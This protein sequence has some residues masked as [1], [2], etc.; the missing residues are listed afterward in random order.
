MRVGKKC[1]SSENFGIRKIKLC[2][3]LLAFLI[4]AHG[5][6]SMTDASAAYRI[7][8]GIPDPS[9]FF[10]VMDPIN[11]PAPVV[12][13]DGTSAYCPSWPSSAS[14]NPKC[15]YVDKTVSGCNN[16]NASGYGTPNAPRCTPPEGTL[17]AGAFVYIN[18]GTYV[19]GDSG[20]QNLNWDGV[21]TAS[22]PIWIVGNPTTKPIIRDQV[23]IGWGRTVSYMVVENLEWSGYTGTTDFVSIRPLTDAVSIDHVV[24]RN[25]TMIG[26]GANIEK[27]AISVGMSSS[28]DEAPNSTI[29]YVV[30]YNNTISNIAR[31]APDEY[32][33][34]C[35]IYHSYHVDSVW[36]LHNTIHT[37]QEDGIAGSHYSNASRTTTNLYIG[38]NTLYNFGANAIDLKSVQGFV[39]S[40]NDFSMPNIKAASG[41]SGGIV[42][43][44]SAQ[45]SS[46][47]S[48]PCTDGWILFNK[49][50]KVCGGL[51]FVSGNAVE[52]M[53]VV[54]N[55]F[56]DID[57]N[58]CGN[59]S[60][61]YPG[62]AILIAS[63]IGN[64]WIVDN[65]FYDNQA[66]IYMEGLLSSANIKIHG[67]IFSNINEDGYDV[68]TG[69]AY[70]STD[71]NYNQFYHPV[72]AG[73]AKI[74]WNG[75]SRNLTYMKG[76]S[77]C[78]NCKEGNPLL[79]N[80]PMDMSLQA[81]SPAKD[82]SVQGPVG[83]TVY[84]LFYATYGIDIKADRVGGARP[85]NTL[86]DIG[87]F[88]FGSL[89]TRDLEIVT[90]AAF[91]RL[92]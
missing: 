36:T 44:H 29:Q 50:N 37:I 66:P 78:T 10:G 6:V 67:N 64:G 52:D 25:C 42:V 51:G 63:M 3:F 8:K 57:S 72:G 28:T 17:Q 90:P 23:G 77:E 62:N 18:A 39:I 14:I 47:A 68:N 49:F 31:L 20:G 88:E 59:P 83:G 2:C 79:V 69:T 19:A 81:S 21:G 12:N 40:E 58:Y 16:S 60:G 22:S 35:A 86:W 15:Y 92:Q 87:A 53:Y 85:Y 71:M 80:P 1:N 91:R 65:T 82:A 56:Y 70:A 46:P 54:G 48:T 61:T 38:G 7:P 13:S 11:D 43:I 45:L 41:E 27:G 26:S 24:I 5:S 33:D 32:R 30:L 74:Y 75:A 55:E 76:I 34:V 89:I 9:D 4:L 73:A 84:D